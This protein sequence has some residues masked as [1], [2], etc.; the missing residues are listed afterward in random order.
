MLHFAHTSLNSNIAIIIK[1]IAW[2]KYRVVIKD[3]P[4]G[5]SGGF[6]CRGRSIHLM[7]PGCNAKPSSLIPALSLRWHGRRGR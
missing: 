7:F 4:Y 6:D 2:S 5:V 1:S 3:S